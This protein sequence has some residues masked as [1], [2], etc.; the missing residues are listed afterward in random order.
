MPA[1]IGFLIICSGTATDLRATRLHRISTYIDWDIP[2]PSQ[3]TRCIS[4][5][6]RKVNVEVRLIDE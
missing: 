6:E 2:Q 3:S 5:R 1:I 4:D